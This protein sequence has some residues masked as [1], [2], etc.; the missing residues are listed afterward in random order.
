MLVRHPFP[1]EGEY[2]VTVTPIFG[3]N[4]SPAGFGWVPCEKIEVVLD[5]ERLQL[6]DWQG[7]RRLGAPTDSC[8]GARGGRGRG[9]A[10][11]AGGGR[12]AAAAGAAAGPAGGG[13]QGPEAV[14]GGRGGPPIAGC[15][16]T[17]P[18]KHA[19]GVAVPPTHFFPVLD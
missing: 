4:M 1:C 3:D 14:F 13:Q 17:T 15:F 19:R 6:I 12:G 11:A 8:G 10:P 9:A 18:R 2:T 16:K 5:G 7:S